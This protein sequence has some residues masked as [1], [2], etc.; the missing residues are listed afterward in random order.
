[1]LTLIEPPGKKRGHSRAAN[2]SGQHLLNFGAPNDEDLEEEFETVNPEPFEARNWIEEKLV[3]GT[4]SS[5]FSTKWKK[6]FSQRPTFCDADLSLQQILR[7]NAKGNMIALYARCLVQK[8]LFKLGDFAQNHALLVI[9]TVFSLFSV[10]CIGLQYVRIETDIVKLWVSEG[11]RLNEELKFFER[12]QDQYGDLNWTFYD[13][14]HFVRESRDPLLKQIKEDEIK[15]SDYQVLIQTV[16]EEG[17]NLLTK[18]GL[19]QHVG[20]LETIVNLQVTHF[21]VNWTLADICFKPGALD[22]NQDSIAYGMKPVLER[23]VPCI[24]I[25]PIDCFFEGSKPIGPNPPIRIGDLPLGSI[26]KM[27]VPELQDDTTWA[28]INPEAVVASLK[29]SFDIG[30]MANFFS[31]TGIGKG[32]LDRPCIEPLDPACPEQSPNYYKS[33][34]PMQMLQIHLKSQNRT[35]QEEL[36]AF[37]EAKADS[38]TGL[39]D[40]LAAFMASEP[41]KT[42]NQTEDSMCKEYRTAFLKWIQADKAKAIR[43]LGEQVSSG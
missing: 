14:K 27:A 4:S 29:D 38:A 43:I 34:G 30:T 40:F 2:R 16:E 41:K 22:I 5:D 17:Q 21:G 28:N 37:H 24:W 12:V 35:V 8:C 11:G 15:T 9:F 13:E 36:A 6:D 33:C 3:G 39:G 1:M 20:L 7:G 26:L 32:Y 42:E 18:E 25:T 10:C 23:L 31:R 19:Q